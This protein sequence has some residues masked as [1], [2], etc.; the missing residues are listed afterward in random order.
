MRRLTAATAPAALAAVWLLSLFAPLLSPGRALASRDIPL[1]HL[2][3]RTAF[4]WLVELGVP[5]WNP[6][7]HGGQ[8]VLSNPSYA[9]FYPPS[10]L[11]FLV[12]PHY[13]LSLLVLLH[14]GI[15]LAGAWAL[16][17]RLGCGRGGAALAAVGYAGCGALLSLLSAFTLFSSMA[18]FPWVLFFGDAALFD[19]GPWL[20]PALWAGFALALQLLNGE[21]STVVMSGLGLLALAAARL[22]PAAVARVAVPCA[23]GLALAAVQLLPTLGRLAD[24]PRSG[25]LSAEQATVWSSPPARLVEIAFPRFFGDPARAQE[26]FYFGW[27][28][29]DRDYPY[30]ASLYPG[31]LLAVLGLA[32]ILKWPVPRRGA[33]ALAALA[34][35][36]LALGRHNPLFEAVREAV[37]VLS[38]L[39]FPEK[40]AVLL[41]LA[42]L[43]A[44]ALGWH[45]LLGEREAGRPQ[46]ADFPLALAG[47]LLATAVTLAALVHQAPRVA[48]WFIRAHGAPGLSPERQAAGLDFLRAESWMAVATAAAVVGLL[49]LCRW[50]RPPRRL[51]EGLAVLLLGL[52]LW[53]YGHGLVKTLPASVYAEPPRLAAPLLPAQ[54]RM[55]VEPLPEGEPEL[56][57]RVGDPGEALA[58]ANI[59]RL[60]PYS[61]VLWL[62]PYALHEDYDLM[63]TGWARRSLAVLHA[64]RGQPEVARRYLGAW[65]V[66]TILERKPAA[67]WTAELAQDPGAPP[68]R[69]VPNP[70]LLRR[71]RFVPRAVFHATWEDAVRA[72][73]E[74]GWT[75]AGEEHCVRPGSSPGALGFTV[76]PRPLSINDQG[77]LLRLHYRAE[78]GAF[79]VAA[80]TFDTGWRATLDGGTPLEVWPTAAGQMGMAL[81]PGEHRLELEYTDPLVPLGAAVTGAALLGVLFVLVRWERRHPAGSLTEQA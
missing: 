63:L 42:L 30:V 48:A 77:G 6:W 32:A 21:P 53:R 76:P 68:S 12:A 8:P 57:A 1:F 45:W 73:R 46:S 24:S 25:G 60:E 10:W 37:P 58:R 62:I 80:V 70:H 69:A 41:V 5:G 36:F 17:R 26:G 40:F 78:E 51:L 74:R 65:N 56:F 52:D 13:A 16:A 66:G 3:L 59:A 47:V 22:R 2:P 61:G 67:E 14:A 75:V 15:G 50:R 23:V 18:W 55:Y 72:A 44:G 79:F 54:S 29:H 4:R 39:R 11:V 31:L 33:W 81:P 71:Y 43:F 27:N 34:G 9:A 64:E 38:V 19:R 7:L 20:R 35:A 49:A 28:L